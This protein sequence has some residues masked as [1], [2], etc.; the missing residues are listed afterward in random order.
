MIAADVSLNLS[1]QQASLNP[2]PVT[3]AAA[4][5][6][7]PTTFVTFITG[8]TTIATITPPTTGAHMLALIFTTTTPGALVT[9]GNIALATTVIT[10]KS[11]VFFV[12]DPIS[13]KYYPTG[14]TL[15]V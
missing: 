11:P 12:Y 6:I 9:S 15:G 7:A 14:G 8:T 3:I 10:S 4:T 13:G 5:T 2:L 1:I